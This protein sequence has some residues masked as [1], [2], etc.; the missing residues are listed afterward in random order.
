MRNV[1]PN[2][3][4][5]PPRLTTQVEREDYAIRIAIK[6]R[7]AWPRSKPE[8]Q[9]RILQDAAAFLAAVREQMIDEISALLDGAAGP[10]DMDAA[11]ALE[12][13]DNA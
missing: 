9:V 3:K 2:S 7:N 1:H 4:K 8:E 13:A 5:T 10:I 12:A 6:F 11:L